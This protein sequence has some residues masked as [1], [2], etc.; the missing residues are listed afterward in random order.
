MDYGKNRPDSYNS[1][2]Q[3]AYIHMKNNDDYVLFGYLVL[4]KS[5]E[6]SYHRKRNEY[7]K[8]NDRQTK[9]R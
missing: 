1:R 7:D 6:V 4:I 5:C 2:F 9:R 3:S 8:M